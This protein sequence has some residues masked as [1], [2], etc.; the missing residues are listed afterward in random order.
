MAPRRPPLSTARIARRKPRCSQETPLS[1]R[2][3]MCLR[4]AMRGIVLP[5]FAMLNSPMSPGKASSALA[6]GTGALRDVDHGAL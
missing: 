3:S 6:G 5:A 1:N 4:S 2:G